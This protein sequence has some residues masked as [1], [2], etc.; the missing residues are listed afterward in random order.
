[1]PK[2]IV[3]YIPNGGAIYADG[4][5]EDEVMGV[6]E[7][8]RTFPYDTNLSVSSTIFIYFLRA[9]VA[10]GKIPCENVELRYNG[11][12]LE[13]DKNG[14][15]AHWP[16]GFADAFDRALNKLLDVYLK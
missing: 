16:R 7:A 6:Y 8:S 10:E 13:M 15:L 12:I 9:L 1:M 3:T 4:S 11:E 5:I 14:R 2:L